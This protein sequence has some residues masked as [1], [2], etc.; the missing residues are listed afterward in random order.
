MA[1]LLLPALLIFCLLSS[2][3]FHSFYFLWNVCHI[4]TSFHNWVW[5]FALATV[6]ISRLRLTS[7]QQRRRWQQPRQIQ[8]NFSISF[9]SHFKETITQKVPRLCALYAEMDLD[10]LHFLC[11]NNPKF[12][13]RTDEPF[14]LL[15]ETKTL[16][17]FSHHPKTNDQGE[18]LY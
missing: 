18:D 2:S 17:G 1:P 14:T 4:L 11:W 9:F 5:A 15:L 10:T 8:S 6:F 7:E 13:F 3:F 12:S 16:N